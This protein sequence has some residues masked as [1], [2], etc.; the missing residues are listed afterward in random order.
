MNNQ[1]LTVNFGAV[2]DNFNKRCGLSSEENSHPVQ[3]LA[4][5][6]WLFQIET[7]D[8]LPINYVRKSV[9]WEILKATNW[10]VISI[11]AGISIA[12]IF[13]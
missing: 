3:V 2:E 1:K 10:V 11:G 6:K 12:K 4:H 13:S 8:D 9:G 5:L 7:T